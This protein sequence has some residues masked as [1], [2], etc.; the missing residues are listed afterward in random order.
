MK[1]LSPKRVAAGAVMACCAT[2]TGFATESSVALPAPDFCVKSVNAMGAQMGRAE[3][4][5]DERGVVNR[6]IVR[7]NGVD[8]DVLCDPETGLVRDVAPRDFLPRS[9]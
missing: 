5:R 6:Y 8:Y 2:A 7:S 4:V 3:P 9:N 1:A